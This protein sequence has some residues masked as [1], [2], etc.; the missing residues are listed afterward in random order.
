MASTT[1]IPSICLPRIYFQFDEEYVAGVF[2]AMFGTDINGNSCVDHIDF[3]GR[4]DRNTGEPYW[5]CFVHFSNDGFT[6]TPE[7]ENYVGRINNGEVVNI[8]Y[9]YPKKWYWK[10][11]KN[12]KPNGPADS[13]ATDNKQGPRIM[14]QEDQ[15]EL[16]Q[17]KTNITKEEP[18]KKKNWADVEE[19][20]DMN[21]RD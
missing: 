18:K 10:S 7:I 15:D 21:A 8:Q 1:A 20:E 4:Q 12:N 13:S 3:L 5:L 16:N 11:S 17:N 6:S 2:N 9:D 14:P 19:E